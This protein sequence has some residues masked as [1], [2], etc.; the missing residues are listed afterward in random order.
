MLGLYK[1]YIRHS[2]PLR[3]AARHS[4]RLFDRRENPGL[5]EF[6]FFDLILVVSAYKQTEQHLLRKIKIGNFNGPERVADF[7]D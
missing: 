2:K 6:G 3:R 5:G 4:L 7:C 1:E